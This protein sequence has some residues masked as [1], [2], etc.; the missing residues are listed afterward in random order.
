[1]VDIEI[2]ITRLEMRIAKLQKDGREAA[3]SALRLLHRYRP[4]LENAVV[5]RRRLQSDDHG[6]VATISQTTLVNDWRSLG[7]FLLGAEKR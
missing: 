3:T 1:M 2:L 6:L 5:H 7:L 4:A